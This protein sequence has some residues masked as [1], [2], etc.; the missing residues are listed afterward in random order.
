VSR[1]VVAA[2][3]YLIGENCI[4]EEDD[5]GEQDHPDGGIMLILLRDKKL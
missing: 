2:D 1:D 4:V 5:E 3:E